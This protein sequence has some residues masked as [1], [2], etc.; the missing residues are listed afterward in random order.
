TVKRDL[1]LSEFETGFRDVRL[2]DALDP[3]GDFAES[4]S[5]TLVQGGEKVVIEDPASAEVT[6]Y[7][8]LEKVYQYLLARSNQNEK[9]TNF[10]FLLRCPEMTEEEKREKYSEYGSHELSFFLSRKDPVFFERVIRPYLANTK[11][12]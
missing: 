7:H 5:G 10:S 6:W 12:K 11:E 1:S 2:A 8:N 4:K 3:Q 9:L